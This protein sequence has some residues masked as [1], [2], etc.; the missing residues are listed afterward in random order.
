M[1]PQPV[2]TSKINILIGDPEADGL[3]VDFHFQCMLPDDATV[4]QLAAWVDA[5]F[6]QRNN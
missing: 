5:F 2:L 4:D 6:Q 3:P 1:I